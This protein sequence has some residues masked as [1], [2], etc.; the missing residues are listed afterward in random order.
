LTRSSK[1]PSPLICP[2][3]QPTNFELPINLAT[4]EALDLD[5]PSSLLQRADHVIQ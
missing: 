4:A 5:I 3:E 2:W 1:A